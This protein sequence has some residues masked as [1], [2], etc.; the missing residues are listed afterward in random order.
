[1]HK[2]HLPRIKDSAKHLYTSEANA[3]RIVME[4]GLREV[5][6]CKTSA[7]RDKLMKEMY[8]LGMIY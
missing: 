2:S 5:M 3:A 8:D 6:L 7:D 1:M 4:L